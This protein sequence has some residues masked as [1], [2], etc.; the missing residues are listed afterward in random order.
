LRAAVRLH[1]CGHDATTADWP[2]RWPALVVL[3]QWLVA[4]DG[5]AVAWFMPAG[6]A[7]VDVMRALAGEGREAE[8]TRSR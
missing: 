3:F 6:I 8:V 4:K 1:C 2:R 5:V 7:A